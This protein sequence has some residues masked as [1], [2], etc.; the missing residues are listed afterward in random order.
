MQKLLTGLAAAAA[1]T[2]CAS[3]AQADC[4]DYHNVTA[5][6]RTAGRDR[7]HEHA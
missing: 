1:L 2:L 7:G 6:V 3:V 5:G 4:C